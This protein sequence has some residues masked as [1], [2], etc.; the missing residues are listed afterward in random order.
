MIFRGGFPSR[1][2]GVT[3]SGSGV[4]CDL[5][6][7]IEVRVLMRPHSNMVK[8]IDKSDET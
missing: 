6:R 4:R 2:S 8:Y 5:L 1:R 7:G 3:S